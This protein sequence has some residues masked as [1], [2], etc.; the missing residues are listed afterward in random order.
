M[1]KPNQRD[2]DVLCH[3][4]KPLVLFQKLF[5]CL[6]LERKAKLIAPSLSIH[7]GSLQMS[8]IISY[9]VIKLAVLRHKQIINPISR[10]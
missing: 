8:D 4:R 6:E 5:R 9:C 2:V 3:E 1:M 10:L 7:V